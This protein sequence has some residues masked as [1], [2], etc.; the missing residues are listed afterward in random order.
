[1]KLHHNS[2]GRKLESGGVRRHKGDRKK[3]RK[4]EEKGSRK[5]R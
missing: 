1:M 3:N 5:A 2:S 4:A